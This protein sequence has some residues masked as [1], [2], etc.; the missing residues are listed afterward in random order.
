MATL[1]PERAGRAD[2]AP[3]IHAGRVERG[4]DL[5]AE[6][7]LAHASGHRRSRAHP[8]RGDRLVAALAAE[9]IG[10]RRADQRLVE[11]GQARRID[12]HVEMQRAGDED[13]DHGSGP[14]ERCGDDALAGRRVL[15]RDGLGQRG[16]AGQPFG[17]AR[18]RS[19]SRIFVR[20]SSTGSSPDWSGKVSK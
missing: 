9:A 13:V 16:V 5:L 18:R 1:I 8:R 12:H 11:R 14:V 7:V 6:T 20:A 4:E 2:H 19:T 10:H 15:P 17:D 3:A